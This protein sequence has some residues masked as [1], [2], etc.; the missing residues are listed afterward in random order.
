M[1]V[2]DKKI[3]FVICT[4][5]RLFCNECSNYISSLSVPEGYE[6]DIITIEEADYIT[7]AYNAAMR[8]SDAKYKVY[9]HQD[10]FIVNKD[11]IAEIL[12]IFQDEKIGMIGFAGRTKI[13]DFLEC[14]CWDKGSIYSHPVFKAYVDN[15]GDVQGK[16][17]KV[18]AIDGMLMATQYDIPWREDILKGWDFYDISQSIEFL[19]KGYHIVVPNCKEPWLL[20]D[21]GMMNYS[22]YLEWEEVFLK[23]YGAFIEKLEDE[24]IKKKNM[25]QVEQVIKNLNELFSANDFENAEKLIIGARKVPELYNDIVAIYDANLSLNKGDYEQMWEAIR[26]GLECNSKNYELYVLLGEYYLQSNANQAYLCFENALFYC[27]NDTDKEQIQA[28]MDEL[29]ET[30]EITVNKTSF[31]ILSYNTL[32]FTRTC[33]ESIRENTLPS[34]REIVIVDNASSDGSLEWLKEQNDIILRANTENSG[35]PRGCNQGV[36]VASKENDIFL[37]NNDT[38][39][40]PNALFWLRMGLYESD[41]VGATGSIT[42]FAAN[43]Q[44]I[45]FEDDSTENML[46]YAIA[47]NI[48]QK[49]PYQ[50]RL[51]L[52]GYALLIKRSVYDEV[53]DLDER[54]SPG[55]F[56]D[57]DY[58]VRVI[59]AGYKN[60]LCTNSFILHFGSKSF[61]KKAEAYNK[62]LLTNAQKFADKWNLDPFV[63]FNMQPYLLN[64]IAEEN[65]ANIRVLDVGCA[66]GANNAYIKSYY[67]NAKMYGVEI[68]K[69]AAELA[70]HVADV[71]CGDV[72]T[73]ELPWEK[74]S[75]DYIICSN[76]LAE[77]KAPGETLGVLFKFLKQGGHMIL[78]VPKQD[79][80]LKLFSSLEQQIYTIGDCYVVKIKKQN[81][82]EVH[83]KKIAVC[84]PTYN[85][86]DV[87]E[88]VLSKSIQDYYNYGIDIYY[89]DSS[90]GNETELVVKK[91][92]EAGF[93]NL[94]LV[95]IASEI[96]ADDKMLLIF[97]GEGRKKTYDY[98]WP[99]KD[100][101]YCP[102]ITL[103]KIMAAA[104]E[105]Y[106]AIFLGVMNT[107]NDIQMSTCTYYDPVE[108]YRD[109]G[110]LAT[111]WDV[112]IYN[113][114]SFFDDFKMDKFKEKDVTR[115]F[116]PF[117]HFFNRIAEIKDLKLRLLRDEEIVIGNSE[118]GQSGW[119]KNAFT[120]WQERWI[121]ANRDLP[122]CYNPYKAKV[123]KETAS[124]PWLLGSVDLLMELRALGILTPDKYEEIKVDWELVSDIPLESV[125]KIATDTYDV[126]HDVT[127]LRKSKKA[128]VSLLIKVIS[129][130]K[131]GRL[132]REEI[133]FDSIESYT[134]KKMSEKIG[135]TRE[136]YYIFIGTLYDI[137]EYILSGE[138]SKEDIVRAMQAYISYLIILPD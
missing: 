39:V 71:V 89:Y 100:R 10:V 47:N 33:I 66:C 16:Y 75:F 23:E 117:T 81:Q 11:F 65:E 55:N 137:K 7:Q 42:N 5:N 111:S 80:Y 133:P 113:Q 8:D 106:D 115:S 76:L 24:G 96:P 122:E 83:A 105:E 138:R 91:Y 67:P 136:E 127:L 98:I 82:Q 112:I 88:D 9:L 1:K 12:E 15:F 61:G 62:L 86:P 17:E 63:Y 125:Y 69:E 49:Y 104:E 32:E 28:F 36:E 134:M 114:K 41:S 132:Q 84:V 48:P 135:V 25:I 92:Q 50:E 35:F 93:D 59:K 79:E 110:W 85:H 54:F 19:Q 26:R 30:R 107:A 68:K 58:G 27:D 46:R 126:S 74:E 124:L 77:L 70:S 2:N 6:I 14:L 102:K 56:E 103:E 51:H 31:I 121:K 123:I 53:G 119:T 90:E 72:E 18:Q 38:L 101:S 99:V 108:C 40:P 44:S 109:W 87:V 118:L 130:I 37:L 45:S 97:E 4:N 78:V 95:K 52:I 57:N 60:I 131:E 20:H 34:S 94:Y 21:H 73:M 128:M 29:K 129:L 3:A 22:H 43:Y 64:L 120:I 116:Y 13:K